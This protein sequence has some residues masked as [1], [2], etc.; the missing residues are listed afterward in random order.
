ME[1]REEQMTRTVQTLTVDL[2]SGLCLL[3]ERQS[4]EM[5]SNQSSWGQL[6]VPVSWL[7]GP[8]AGLPLILVLS[9]HLIPVCLPWVLQTL[10][11]AREGSCAQASGR[12]DVASTAGSWEPLCPAELRPPLVVTCGIAGQGPQWS[13]TLHG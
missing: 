5:L 10:E 13:Q 4:R 12:R 9:G 2:T 1:S 8:R 7:R 11:E 3:V 6:Q